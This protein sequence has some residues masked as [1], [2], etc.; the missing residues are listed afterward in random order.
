M[1]TIILQ[2][3]SEDTLIDTMY[4]AAKTC[5][6]ENTI[7]EI[8]ENKI[9]KEDKLKLIK[10]VMDSGHHSIA[11]HINFTIGIDGISRSCS[12]QLVRHRLCTYSQQSQRYINMKDKK[13]FDFVI[14]EKLKTKTEMAHRYIDMMHTIKDFYDELIH[15]GLLPEDARYILPNATCTNITMSTN[16]RNLMHVMGLRLCSRAQWEIRAVYKSIANQ[17]I[18][19]YSFLKDYLVPQCEIDGYCHELTCCGRKPKLDNKTKNK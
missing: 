11:E 13:G 18:E 12:H 7:R 14:P 9:S 3:P 17:L 10:K 2:S 4:I 16:L 1:K 15:E 6:S 8:S 5:Y 19:K